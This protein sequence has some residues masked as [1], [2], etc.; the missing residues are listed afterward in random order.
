MRKRQSHLPQPCRHLCLSGTQWRAS[1]RADRIGGATI[2]Y[3]AN[4]NMV[5]DGGRALAWDGANRLSGITQGG[6]T[7]TFVYG[8]SGSRVK[9]SNAFATTLYPDANVEIDRKPGQDTYKVLQTWNPINRDPPRTKMLSCTPIEVVCNAHIDDPPLN[10]N[11]LV[12]DI[13]SL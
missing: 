5:S 8:P 3:D 7:T 1:A 10:G 4:G 9:K 2:G 13:S 6:A 12:N 11:R